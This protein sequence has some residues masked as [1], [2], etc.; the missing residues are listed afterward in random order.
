MFVDEPRRVTDALQHERNAH[1]LLGY[2][3]MVLRAAGFSEDA[4]QGFA[5]L[6]SRYAMMKA[7][8]QSVPNIPQVA[9]LKSD[10]EPCGASAPAVPL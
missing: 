2:L 10:G 3:L 6:A 7:L 5:R 9:L 8:R 1:G 4:H